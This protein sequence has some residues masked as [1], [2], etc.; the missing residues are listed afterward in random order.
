[1]DQSR[2]RVLSK[3][4]VAD[5]ALHGAQELVGYLLLCIIRARSEVSDSMSS[6]PDS[7]VGTTSVFTAF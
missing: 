4:T 5:L 2:G 3:D 6:L 7:D 1:M